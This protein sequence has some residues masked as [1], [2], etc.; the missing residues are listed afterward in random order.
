MERA[1]QHS[2]KETSALYDVAV[3]IICNITWEDHVP[4]AANSK[5]GKGK[6]GQVVLA[7]SDVPRVGGH[8]DEFCYVTCSGIERRVAIDDRVR[9]AP[10]VVTFPRGICLTT[11]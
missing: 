6:R 4:S 2:E 1:G 9:N 7:L 10:Y 3:R 8:P 5:G 11:P